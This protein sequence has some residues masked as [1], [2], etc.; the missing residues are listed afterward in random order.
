LGGKLGQLYKSRGIT[1][2][3]KGLKEMYKV[4]NGKAKI[5]KVDDRTYDVT[6]RYSKNFCP[7]GGAFNHDVAKEFQESIC[8]PYTQ[9]FLTSF[10]P[11]LKYKGEVHQCII[12]DNNKF[13]HYTVHIEEKEK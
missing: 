3:E 9:G 10:N 8:I 6:V 1:S 13:C 12:N 2:I 4:M 11:E 5:F 7:V